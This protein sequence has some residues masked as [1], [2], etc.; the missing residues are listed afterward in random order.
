MFIN[1]LSETVKALYN[2]SED[3]VLPSTQHQGIF[4]IF[5][6]DNVDK[7]SSSVTAAG[8]FHGTGVTH[9][10]FPS[11]KNPRIQ[12]K[13][14]SWTGYCEKQ[15]PD[16]T[17]NILTINVP[18]PLIHYKSSSVE[19]QYLLMKVA[20]NYAKYLNPGQVDVGVSD[21]LLYALK[22]P[23]QMAYSGKFEGYFFSLV[24]STQSRHH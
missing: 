24:V 20:V 7:N 21:L 15:S 8:H 19:L 10:Q 3:K 17:G 5:V 9:L 18:L 2:D 16:K 12:R 4:I 6:D 22:R 1:E 14:T 11:E 23:I 13:S